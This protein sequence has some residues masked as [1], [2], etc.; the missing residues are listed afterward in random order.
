MLLS[1]KGGFSDGKYFLFPEY[2]SSQMAIK[3]EKLKNI[4]NYLLIVIIFYIID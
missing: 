1:K 3:T 4:Q 2:I